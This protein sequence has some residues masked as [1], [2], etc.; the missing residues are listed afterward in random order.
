MT[1]FSSQVE[2]I[3]TL[4]LE[5]SRQ[6]HFAGYDPFDGLNG[7]LFEWLPGLKSGIFGL[8]WIQFFKQ[9]PIN[10]RPLLG[11]PKRR[12]PKGIGLFI[13]LCQDSCPVQCR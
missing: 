2:A 5:Q 7:K 3:S 10:F 1:T 11:V 8:A 12:N 13:P 4:V 9:S 6:D